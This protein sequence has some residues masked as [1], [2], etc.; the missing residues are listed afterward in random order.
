MD[1]GQADAQ[2]EALM[3]ALILVAAVRARTE[4]DTGRPL[5]WLM[6]GGF[7]AVLL[8]SAYLWFT[9]EIRPRRAV[10]D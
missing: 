2:V 5:T 8:G 7:I 3:V 1:D 9:M 10:G 4:F 6:L